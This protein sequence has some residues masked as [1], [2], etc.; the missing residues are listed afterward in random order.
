MQTGKIASIQQKRL[1]V[2]RCHYPATGLGNRALLRYGSKLA[3]QPSLQIFDL[4]G[5]LG[6]DDAWWIRSG[7]WPFDPEMV[8]KYP[9]LVRP[10]PGSS[11]GTFVSSTTIR[12]RGEQ[13]LFH[14]FIGRAEF[15]RGGAHPIQSASVERSIGGLCSTLGAPWPVLYWNI[16][17]RT[18]GA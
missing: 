1:A 9:D 11:T 2:R 3:F 18:E 5:A 4:P 14:A 7:P 12:G 13:Q 16:S 8:Q 10:R 17:V 6:V 15:G